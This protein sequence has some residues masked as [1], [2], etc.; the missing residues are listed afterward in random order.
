MS[1]IIKE[2][3]IFN[4]SFL[5]PGCGN[6]HGIRTKDYRDQLKANIKLLTKEEIEVL[7]ETKW[8]AWEFNGDM[9]SLTLS[10]SVLV[11]TGGK[12]TQCHSFVKNGMIQFLNDCDHELAGKTVEL[13]DIDYG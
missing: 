2:I 3:G 5:C 7:N 4:Y 12:I 13:P 1:K 11:K 10:P 6:H 8:S 9:E